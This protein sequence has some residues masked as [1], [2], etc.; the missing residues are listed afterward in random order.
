M[1]EAAPIVSPSSS[2]PSPPPSGAPAVPAAAASPTTS[3]PSSTPASPSPAGGGLTGRREVLGCRPRASS[4]APT[5]ATEF[6]RLTATEA[7]ETS[8][9]GIVPAPDKYELKFDADYK[10]PAGMEWSWDTQDAPLIN[11]A[12]AFANA[13][14]M[15]Q[16]NFSK[17]LGLYASSRIGEQQ[18]SP[19]LSAAEL[20]KLG[21]NANTRVDAIKTWISAMAGDK[22]GAM[23]RVLD[24]APTASTVEAFET[25]IAALHLAGRLRQSGRLARRQ[26]RPPAAPC[27]ATPTTPSSP[28]PKRLTYAQQ[29]DQTRFTNG[30]G[31]PRR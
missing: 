18:C 26:F 5:C 31:S 6:D 19:T 25:L 16:D 22:A 28:T 21:A 11:E 14:G 30:R 17:L 24:H 29:F 12:R 4:R 9:Q 13:T 8:R 3:T 2:S 23:L 7:A 27:S 15:G 10:L 1:P 20:G